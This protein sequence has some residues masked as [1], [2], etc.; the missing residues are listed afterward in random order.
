MHSH[1]VRILTFVRLVTDVVRIVNKRT[2]HIA[3]FAKGLKVIACFGADR[4]RLSIAEVA[5]LTGLDR[6][7]ARRCLLTLH[8]EGYADY[9]GKFFKLTPRVLR[10]GLGVLAAMPLAQIVQPWLDQLSD[11]VGQSSSVSILDETEIVY[12]A[13]AAQRRVMSIGLMPGSRLPCHCTSMGR[14]LLAALPEA[15]A[16][17]L[18][19]RSDLTPRT[20]HSLTDPAAIM[21]AIAEVRAQGHCVIDQEIELGLRSIAVPVMSVRGQVVAALNI[22]AAAVQSEP[23]DLV[24]LYLPQMMKMQAGLRRVLGQ[25]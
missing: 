6:A 14:V 7:T 8:N 21:E 23:A 11:Q 10:L 22:G 20:V 2:D 17:A 24:R 12:L 18:L 4:S 16:R 3:A 13:R 1:C 19:D 5:T 15:E 9:D 25:G